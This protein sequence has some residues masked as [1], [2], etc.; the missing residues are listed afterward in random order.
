MKNKIEKMLKFMFVF[1]VIVALA[2]PRPVLAQDDQ[3][4]PEPTSEEITT[5]V[6]TDVP[7][8]VPTE[9][10][11]E[12]ATEIPVEEGV[13]DIFE[14]ETVVDIVQSIS[15][16]NLQLMDE[17]GNL[18]AL[19]SAVVNEAFVSSDPYFVFEGIVY[20]YTFIGG[21]CASEVLPENC[22]QST[23][24][25][26][27][28]LDDSKYTGQELTIEAGDYSGNDLIIA[29]V[30]NFKP[31]ENLTVNSVT[32]ND[33]AE[34]NWSMIAG[35]QYSLTSGSVF[36][37]SGATIT[38]GL[39]MSTDGTVLNVGEGTFEESIDIEFDNLTLQ[40]AGS[41][42][43]TIFVSPNSEWYGVYV[44][45]DNVTID[46]FTIDGK[47]GVD[48]GVANYLLPAANA[49]N[50]VIKNNVIKNFS[51]SVVVGGDYGVYLWT[52][53]GTTGTKAKI[54]NNSFTTGQ[55]AI[56]LVNNGYA[57]VTANIISD[58]EVGIQSNNMWKA[59]PDG[60]FIVNGNS[61]DAARYGIWDNLQY[62]NATSMT[63]SNNKIIG[64]RNSG[65]PS[66]GI[67]VTSIQNS[68]GANLT[69]NDVIGTDFGVGLWNVPSS[70]VTI[71]GGTL[72]NN[73]FGIKLDN[74][75]YNSERG[76]AL[77]N[78]QSASATVN[79]VTII[80]AENHAFYVVDNPGVTP[81]NSANE[82]NLLVQSI[83]TINSCVGLTSGT[84]A[85]LDISSSLFINV[86]SRCSDIFEGAEN[87]SISDSDLDNVEDRFDNC[88]VTYN[89]DQADYDGDGVGN[90]C[91]PITY[92]SQMDSDVDGIKDNVDN[93][94]LVPNANQKDTDGDG[95][96]DACDDTPFGDLQPLLV[97]VTGGGGFSFFNCNSETILRLPSS[98]FVMATSDFCNMQGELTEQLEEVLPED[99][100]EGGPD[101]EFGMNLTILDNLTPLKYIAEPGRLTYSFRIPTDLRDK[102][103]TVFFW[104]PTLKEGAGDWVELPVYAE[105]E[106]GT[107][108]ITSLHEEEPT[109]MRMILEGV[110]KNDLGTRFEFVTNFPGMFILAVK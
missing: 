4:T 50:L 21:T 17:N 3:T 1:I 45:S 94:V 93:C 110:K 77:G 6:P 39:E 76:L 5:E 32:L 91:D 96:G 16:N 79:G 40:G 38:D 72:R 107:P 54:D 59:S 98:D 13:A 7:T 84:N 20:G 51:D 27:S 103:F 34:I 63:I 92:P 65:K 14:D 78:W 64:E 25:I 46:G 66:Y 88:P 108:V 23:N 99:L 24:P 58:V 12:A 56:L 104:D 95:I 19:G 28:A 86:P 73:L 87:Q 57:D 70:L 10:L 8:D 52:T 35:I 48:D 15:D 60:T 41:D 33:G 71:T 47:N 106:D 49:D 62:S 83:K 109:E 36:V 29:K 26:Q 18:L 43:T 37:N 22:V 55:R 97:P 85:Y 89:P 74:D 61:I 68:V 81:S 90:A 80:D 69:N 30:V 2:V 67:Y 9:V 42:K 101:F 53:T 105:E 82:L 44:G 11:T 102:E 100:P 31:T 75:S